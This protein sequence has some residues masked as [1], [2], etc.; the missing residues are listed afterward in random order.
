LIAQGLIHCVEGIGAEDGP[1]PDVVA[2]VEIRGKSHAES[3]W[4]AL[5][6]RFNKKSP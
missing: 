6:R 2:E 5:L 1:V 3:R 4:C